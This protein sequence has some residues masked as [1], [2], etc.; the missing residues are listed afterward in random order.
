MIN[1]NV[2]T[3][4]M[5]W[6]NVYIANELNWIACVFLYLQFDAMFKVVCAWSSF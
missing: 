4:K 1:K 5:N 2:E 3:C 6:K